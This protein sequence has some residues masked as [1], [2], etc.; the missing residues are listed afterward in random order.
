MKT[1]NDINKDIFFI[2]SVKLKNP[3]FN[4]FKAGLLIKEFNFY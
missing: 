2:T 3:A 1:I 4:D